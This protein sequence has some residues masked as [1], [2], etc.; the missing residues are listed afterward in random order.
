VSSTKAEL[1]K[2]TVL[3]HIHQRKELENYLLETP[4]IERALMNRISDYN[5]RTGDTIR[6][7]EDIHHRLQILS[8]PMKQKVSAQ[9]QA[10]RTSFERAKT[11]GLDPATITQR[12]MSSK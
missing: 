11:P 9:F 6:Y 4:A 12:P 1:Q 10:K 7:D 3:A 2:F 8:E 5:K